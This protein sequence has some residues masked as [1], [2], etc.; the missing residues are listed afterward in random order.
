[1]IINGS[2]NNYSS[3]ECLPGSMPPTGSLYTVRNFS[4]FLFLHVY[5]MWSVCMCAFMFIY[6]CAHKCDFLYIKARGWWFLQLI[7]ALFTNT[8]TLSEPRAS[9]TSKSASASASASRVWEYR[10]ALGSYFWYSPFSDNNLMNPSIL[11]A[12]C[13]FYIIWS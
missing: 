9:L 1:M 3:I 11:S 13:M 4:Y 2:Y 7:S 10:W 8:R 12:P 6:L 5:V